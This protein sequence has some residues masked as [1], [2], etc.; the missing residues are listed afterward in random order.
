[1]TQLDN[2]IV[3]ALSKLNRGLECVEA[4]MERPSDENR[5]T[6]ALKALSD[7]SRDHGMPIAIVGGLG[8]I[9]YGYPAA[10]QDIDIAVRKDQLAPLLNVASQYGF[11]IVWQANSGWHTLEFGDVEI[12]IVPEGG[13]ANDHAPTQIPSPMQLGV[14]SG[15][16]YA[17]IEGWM[18][19][20]I[21]SGRQKD[22]AHV[23][24]VLKKTD[25]PTVQAIRAYLGNVHESY[26]ATLDQ[27]FA[28]AQ[29]ELKQEKNR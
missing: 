27:L 10:T 21:S 29:D 14:V 9:R 1:M 28:D 8:A 22:R 24:E 11:R 16:G 12:N 19:L 6:L 4:V 18:E 26:V 2:N 3:E 23:V 25:W 15:L 20:K 5:F 17:S 13:R 7:L